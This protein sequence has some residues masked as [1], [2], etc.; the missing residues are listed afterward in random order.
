MGQTAHSSPGFGAEATLVALLMSLLWGMN[1]VTV[2]IA[3]TGIGPITTASVRL[4][5]TLLLTGAW[6]R[7]IPGQTATLALLGL[8]YGIIFGLSSMALSLSNNLG[9]LAIANQLSVPIS[10]ILGIWILGERLSLSRSV[11]LFMATGGVGVMVFD[12]HIARD[13]PSLI[14]I[15]MNAAALACASLLQR[16]L[17]NV[18]VRVILAW[19]GLIGSLTL[20]PLGVTFEPEGLFRL[21]H[22]QLPAAISLTFAV[23]GSTIIAPGCM[24]WLLQRHDVSIVMPISLLSTIVTLLAAHWLLSSPITSVMMI[25]G[26]AVLAGL[27]LIMHSSKTQ[28]RALRADAISVSE[29]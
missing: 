15:T 6:L 19:S 24:A 4:F 3:L 23:L 21:R 13:L 17:V 22:L 7:P 5:V 29:R 2:K 27:V 28:S 10:V 26:A 16:R 1:I 12:P 14:L 20:I 11:G 25:S 18:P 9:A 8:T